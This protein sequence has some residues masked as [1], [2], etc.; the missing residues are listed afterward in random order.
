MCRK[1]VR[2][3]PPNAKLRGIN[4]SAVV[5]RVEQ[6]LRLHQEYGLQKTLGYGADWC[7]DA[8]LP[9]VATASFYD[10]LLHIWKPSLEGSGSC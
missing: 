10:R 9:V 6:G 8:D 2:P 1:V 5:R 7:H 4:L 3:V